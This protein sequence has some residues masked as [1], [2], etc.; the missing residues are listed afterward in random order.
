[1]F[2][3]QRP[4]FVQR[5]IERRRVAC[6]RQN[7]R[8]TSCEP[9]KGVLSERYHLPPSA[10]ATFVGDGLEGSNVEVV[11]ELVSLISSQ[12]AY[13]INS[14]AIR[15]ADEMLTTANSVLQ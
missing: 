4:N 9:E 5:H 15:A 6:H 14:R 3:E 1:M 7:R 2:R 12:R 10:H 8:R 11:D 13:E